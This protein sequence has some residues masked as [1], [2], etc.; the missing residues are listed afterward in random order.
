MRLLYK[1]EKLSTS[2]DAFPNM[3]SRSRDFRITRLFAQTQMTARLIGP[4]VTRLSVNADRI[5]HL[6]QIL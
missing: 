1:P 6:M 2:A 5:E 4:P 3:S